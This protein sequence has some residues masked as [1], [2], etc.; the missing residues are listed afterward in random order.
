MLGVV[1]LKWGDKYP[2]DHVN[3]LHR[4]VRRHLRREHAFFCLTDNPEGLD[5]GVAVL[6]LPDLQLVGW[7]NKL[8]LFSADFPLRGRVLFLDL[9]L[10]ILRDLD[11]LVD[12]EAE[13]LFVSIADYVH[14]REFNTSVFHWQ[15]GAPELDAVWREFLA[16]KSALDLSR[17]ANFFRYLAFLRRRLALKRRKRVA[18]MG[19]LTHLGRY[20]GSQKW[21]SELIWDKPWS[22][23]FPA[24][25]C[26]SYK[27]GGASHPD[28]RLVVFEGRPKPHECLQLPWVRENW[29]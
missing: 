10:V 4:M 8:W 11:A 26:G 13:R 14:E 12:F 25:W 24:G 17:R 5:E 7:W 29:G 20:Q 2:P 21:L 28:A 1:C 16:F 23:A 22:A 3:R 15:A 9:D 6:P 27:R 19:E 18:S